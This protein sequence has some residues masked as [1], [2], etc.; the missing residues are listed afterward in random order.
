MN[1]LPL[2]YIVLNTTEQPVTETVSPNK[3]Y[4]W[5]KIVDRSQAGCKASSIP[6]ANS[7]YTKRESESYIPLLCWQ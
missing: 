2:F 1:I 5:G 7:G 3:L 6:Q 4:L